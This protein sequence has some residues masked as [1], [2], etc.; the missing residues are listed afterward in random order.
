LSGYVKDLGLELNK[1]D[2]IF[3]GGLLSLPGIPVFMGG[4]TE[5]TVTMEVIEFGNWLK[6][7]GEPYP[8][9]TW[10]TLI[11]GFTSD[12]VGGTFRGESCKVP[13][14]DTLR[15]P[16]TEKS[17]KSGGWTS[18][19]GVRSATA[20]TERSLI[21]SL[22]TE[23]NNLYNLGLGSDTIHDRMFVDESRPRRY[24]C[25]GGS[26][27]FN[28]GNN[29]ADRGHEVIICGVRGWRPNKTAVE[30]MSAKVEEALQYMTPHD[31]IILH[32][33]DNVAYMSRSEEGGDL[34][35]RRYGNGE[36]HVEGDLVL[37]SKDRLYMFFKNALPLLKLLEGLIVIF[38]TPL[39]RYLQEGCCEADDHA[40]NRFDDGFEAGLRKGLMEIRGYFKDFLFTNNLRFK[41]LN[42]GM[43]VPTTDASGDP[44]WGEDP[45]H[46]LYGGY[47]AIMD[48]VLYEADSMCAGG[49]RAGEDIAPPSK[50]PRTEVARPRWVE[51]KQTPVVM[52]GGY[53][54]SGGGRQQ[55][56]QRG[57]P[58]GGMRGG[59]RGGFR[60][61]FRGRV[62]GARGWQFG[63]Y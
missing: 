31:V 41:I 7:T 15:N 14:P 37:A 38:L 33:F 26:H 23:L 54:N 16:Q 29:L 43:C 55:F 2:R 53:V 9:Q 8:A 42:P 22:V 45:V 10:E 20:D 46:P 63:G 30:E 3:R 24:L 28:E 61:G 58:R 25:I 21:I 36:F 18:P 13:L 57:G 40:P 50:K 6:T 56:E 11:S 12:P 39:P 17:W 48:A 5:R 51:S 32:L 44:L 1:L 27:A 52:H 34:P 19:C 47:D 59:Q 62:W 4:C 60:G 35:I 49:K